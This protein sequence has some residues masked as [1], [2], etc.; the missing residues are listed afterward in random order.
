VRIWGEEIPLLQRSVGH[1][2]CGKKVALAHQR[3]V[4]LGWIFEMCGY[5]RSFDLWVQGPHRE[6]FED[7]SGKISRT[8]QPW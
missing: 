4:N 1:L 3:G 8:L 6:I 5:R 7:V 2:K